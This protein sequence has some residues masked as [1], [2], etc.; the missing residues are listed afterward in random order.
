MLTFVIPAAPYHDAVLQEA[1]AS[2]HAQTLVCKVVVVKDHHR[3]GAGWAR[4]EGLKQVDTPFVSFL[5][6][7]DLLEPTF[8]E[9]CLR[10]YDGRRYV[11]TDWYTDR[12]VNASCSAWS[13][14]GTSHIVTTLLPTAFVRFVGG[15]DEQLPGGEDTDL[16]WKLTRS[17]LCGK[18]LSKPLVHYRKGGQRA[19]TFVRSPQYLD[20][21][22]RV[23]TRYEGLPMTC[24]QGCGGEVTEIDVPPTG[25][26]QPGDVLARALWAGNRTERGRSTGRTYPR[27][28]NNKRLWMDGRDIDAAPHLFARE[29]ELPGK[30]AEVDFQAFAQ[31]VMQ[32]ML[33][34]P[35]QKP[36]P[37]YSV[38][39][40][41]GEVKANVANVLRLYN[42]QPN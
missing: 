42:Q 4:N 24:T 30:P 27:T 11:Y 31:G 10:A 37:V 20:T 15:F 19:E 6:A 12:R 35:V 33:G 25:E 36:E 16:Y 39:G 22:R 32:S 40:V 23:M 34:A 7:D 17:G 8:A 3:Q 21:M 26:Q 41:Q 29:V 18:R 5:D 13:G 14:D 38:Y 9:D 1:L 2:V 28:G